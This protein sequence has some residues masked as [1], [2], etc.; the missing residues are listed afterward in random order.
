MKQMIEPVFID[1]NGVKR[2][3][4]NKI[5]N[6]V[7]DVM[8]VKGVYI[9]NE[10]H[11]ADDGTIDFIDDYRHFNQLLGYSVCG[12]ADLR[13]AHANGNYYGGYDGY[14]DYIDNMP[15]TTKSEL[16]HTIS[17][18]EVY[19]EVKN[20]VLGILSIQ[21]MKFKGN[22]VVQYIFSNYPLHLYSFLN[23]SEFSVYDK[24]QILQ[25]LGKTFDEYFEY[26]FNKV[27]MMCSGDI[28]LDLNHK[29]ELLESYEKQL[30]H[31]NYGGKSDLED[32]IGNFQF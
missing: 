19:E 9:L 12:F 2:F 31:K 30:N 15:L 28:S 32:M 27:E 5:I 29:V 24:R 26:D 1:D 13:V 25:L 18:I 11:K 4:Q 7:I 21:K 10:L 8:R 16:K 6:A 23:N 20:P 14:I 22:K 3:Y 17:E